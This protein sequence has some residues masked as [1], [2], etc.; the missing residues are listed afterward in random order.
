[1]VKS[2][3]CVLS[4]EVY[5]YPYCGRPNKNEDYLSE[6][7]CCYTIRIRKK[8]IKKAKWLIGYGDF[9]LRLTNGVVPSQTISLPISPQTPAIMRSS[10]SNVGF[11]KKAIIAQV[12]K[13]MPAEIDFTEK[14]IDQL[15]N[16]SIECRNNS[17]NQE[18]LI[19]KISNLRGG[20]DIVASLGIIGAI[21]IL[22]TND[23]GLAFQPN[24]HVI[25]PPH[26]QWL[27]GNNY[28]PG[29]FGYGKKVGP[30]S[31]TIAGMTQ[32]AGSDKKYPSSGSWDYVD[33]MKE[34]SKQSSNN[35]IEIQVGDQIYTIKNPYREDAYE[36]GYKLADQIYDSIRESDTDICDIAE[37]LGFKADNIKN[38][39]D[40]VFYQKHELD[41]YVSLGEASEYKRFD[42]Y[43]QQALA[44][45]RLETGT[46][47]QD[48][49]TWIKHE[50]T[51]RHHELKYGSG[52]SEA[53]NRAQ[54]R[55]DGAPW[56]NNF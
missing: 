21:I 49:I 29:Q 19:T 42:P 28:Q 25:I 7:I 50:C 48:D 20:I 17:L 9:I 31:I 55:F 4:V 11:S 53:H 23:W 10:H 5:K 15:Y 37:N 12:I 14:E 3:E 16:L 26:L 45:K 13:E 18:E 54:T 44:W 32:N 56:E 46:Y 38:V 33:V 41:Q 22:S 36:L 34:L 1:M 52:Y 39:K 43:I 27:Y 2:K 30:R 24:P 6:K 47:T 8:I 51:E 40:H 35:R